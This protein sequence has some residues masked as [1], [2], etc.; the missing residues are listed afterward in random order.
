MMIWNTCNT[1]NNL[2][3]FFSGKNF[4]FVMMMTNAIN[5]VWRPDLT[6]SI[7]MA[8]ILKY[9]T[10][11]LVA[12]KRI[13]LK[14]AKNQPRDPFLLTRIC[15]VHCYGGLI[16]LKSTSSFLFNNNWTVAGEDNIIFIFVVNC[17]WVTSDSRIGSYQRI[18]SS[19]CGIDELFPVTFR[20]IFGISFI[21][22]RT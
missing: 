6:M 2:S 1:T 10:K 15:S 13:P 19:N 7:S 5:T 9:L 3:N 4:L 18:S 12:V 16:L 8:S 20:I 17:H 21:Q 22:N 14:I 11:K